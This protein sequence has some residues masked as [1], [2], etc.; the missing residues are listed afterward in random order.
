MT[1]PAGWYDD[2][3]G[4]RRWWDGHQ[5][6]D[7]VVAAPLPTTEQP[8]APG[9]APTPRRLSVLGLV[10]LIA[11]GIGVL[12][13]CIPPL[14]VAGW[15]VL[16]L[17]FTASLVSLFLRGSKWPGIAG[18][19][20]T[21][22]GAVLALAVSLVTLGLGAVVEAG[23]PP[24]TP[25]AR[26]SA[27]SGTPTDENDSAELGEDP[28]DIE[29]AEMVSFADLE[30]GDCIPFV[31]YESDDAIS[32]VPVV[33]CDR[34]HTDEVY[35]IYQVEDGEFPGDDALYNA[36]WD[37]CH[38][39]FESFVGVPYEESVLDFYNYTP[40]KSSWMRAADR[41]VHCIA[42]SYDENVTGSLQGTG[43]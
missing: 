21:A 1:T 4:S 35:F 27:E 16:A 41:T 23:A 3:S 5:W 9:P 29:G 26:P 31:E 2:G 15:I 22:L 33:S 19:G 13:A 14:S 12:L 10:G 18:M 6:T 8:T 25:S 7:H 17:A 30:V 37:R 24:V 32:Q 42:F 40:T 39:E 28:A 38:D 20:V 43:R 36:A 34:P 11:A